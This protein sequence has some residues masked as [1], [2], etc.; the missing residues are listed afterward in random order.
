MKRFALSILVLAAGAMAFGMPDVP[1]VPDVDLPD[2][3]IPG[4]DILDNIQVQLDELISATDSLKWLIPELDALD[5]VSA[6]L[7]ELR[8]TD[9]D[10]IGLQEEIDAL[11]AELTVAREEIESVTGVITEDIQDVR[12]SLDTFVEGLPIPSE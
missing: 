12:S 10:V 3:E 11:R 9:P 2:I 7:E 1:D 6:K 5:A 4:L 8:D